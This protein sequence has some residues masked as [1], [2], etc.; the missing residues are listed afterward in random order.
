MDF[1]VEPEVCMVDQPV[2]VRVTA[3]LDR[4]LRRGDQIAFAPP[5]SWSSQPYC[6]TF[7]KEPQT[8]DP[9]EAD[10]VSISAAD[11]RFETSIEQI[12]LPAGSP[13]GHVRKIVGAVAE[14][15][16]P[17]AGEV[18]LW[19]HNY[20]STWLAESATFRVWVGDDEITEGAPTIRTTP[21]GADRLR[22]IVPSCA[23][24]GEP[25]RVQIVSYDRFWNRSSSTFREGVLRVQG[26]PVLERGIA[27]SGS[28]VT[29]ASI[30]EP[31]VYRLLYG[32]QLSNP[33]RIT[34]NPRGPYWGDLHSHDKFHNCGAGESPFHYAR[35]VSCLDFVGVAPDYRGLG[36][37]VW[38]EHV[39]RTEAANEP[40]RFTTILSYEV[41]F[42]RGHHNVYWRHGDAH[43]FDVSDESLCSLDRFLPTLDPTE[44]IVV[45]HHLGIHWRPQE[46]YYPERDP[47]IPLL[48]IYSSHGLSEAF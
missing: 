6:I 27:F 17:A 21:A 43:I 22:I 47:W 44:A 1:R 8:S 18:V 39:R 37:E 20:R 19:L 40:G 28:Y 25:F 29:Q 34:T 35:E 11:V 46:R 45:P 42:G 10:Y 26:G 23:R 24:P 4:P 31:G 16:V 7:T 3:T 5:E 48:E 32:D 13:K 36:P 15:Q 41:G 33:I 38:R 14:G 30:A 12:M 2:E 9:E